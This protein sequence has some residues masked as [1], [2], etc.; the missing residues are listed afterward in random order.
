MSNINKNQNAPSYRT[1]RALILTF[2][3]AALVTHILIIGKIIPYQWV[4]G[5]MSPSYEA[6][7]VQSLVSLVITTLLF[8]FVWRMSGPKTNPKIWQRRALYIV[9]ALWILGFL[10]QLIGTS[11]ERYGMSIVLLVGV[12]G[13]IIL[14][15][16]LPPL[17]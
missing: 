3:S 2:Y 10:M 11:F 7:A 5:G 12:F 17:R 16:N 6:Q 4:N 15:R 13:H 9:T 14:I 8:I 1:I